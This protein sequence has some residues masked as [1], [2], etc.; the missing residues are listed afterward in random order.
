MKLATIIGTVVSTQK[1]DRMDGYKYLLAQHVDFELK[2]EGEPFVTIDCVGA[3]H[4]ELVLIAKGGEAMLAIGD[5]SPP[6]DKA[7]VAV[8]D[9][10][11][12]YKDA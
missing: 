12:Y 10:V 8:V 9:N 5:N 3:G 1:Y 4:G 6:I 2:P 11:Y 7:C